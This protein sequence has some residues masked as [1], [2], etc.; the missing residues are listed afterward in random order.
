MADIF[1]V[2]QV[3]YEF[4]MLP[5]AGPAPPPAAP[6]NTILVDYGNGGGAN[7]AGGR[8]PV[9]LPDPSIFCS[10]EGQKRCVMVNAPTVVKSKAQPMRFDI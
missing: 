3:V 5:P 6:H 10:L 1:H 8:G 7:N 4:L 9:I 2:T